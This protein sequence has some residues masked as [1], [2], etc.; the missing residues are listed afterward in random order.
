M[1]QPC[2]TLTHPRSPAI[3]A[4]ALVMDD[5]GKPFVEHMVIF[6]ICHVTHHEGFWDKQESL[7]GLPG[8]IAEQE[9][10]LKIAMDHRAGYF[11]GHECKGDAMKMFYLMIRMAVASMEEP[12]SFS[13]KESR[14]QSVRG[15][16]SPTKAYLDP[17]NQKREEEKRLIQHKVRVRVRVRGRVRVRV[18]GRVR[19]RSLLHLLLLLVPCLA[20]T[21]SSSRPL[22]K[23]YQVPEIKHR[24]E[25]W[26]KTYQK[27]AA[28]CTADHGFFVIRDIW[29]K[30]LKPVAKTPARKADPGPKP[31][32]GGQSRQR[33]QSRHGEG[34]QEPQRGRLLRNQEPPNRFSLMM[35]APPLVLT[36]KG[37]RVTSR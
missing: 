6:D 10:A 3:G 28:A 33:R 36:L 13:D 1:S 20:F 17:K 37:T 30:E 24:C 2:L 5:D 23:V 34:R 21:A 22:H 16:V 11:M 35:T 7:K 29:G 25:L 4:M 19:V 15:V 32:K 12:A 26:L 31:P 8:F 14:V 18:R 27:I 9:L